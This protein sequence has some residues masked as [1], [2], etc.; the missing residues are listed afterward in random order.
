MRVDVP[1][2]QG[3]LLLAL[4]DTL[5]PCGHKVVLDWVPR[6]TVALA[7]LLSFIDEALF[8]PVGHR[9]LEAITF[10]TS[11]VYEEDLAREGAC[12]DVRRVRLLHPWMPLKRLD[13]RFLHSHNTK[14]ED[15]IS[16]TYL[17]KVALVELIRTIG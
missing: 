10:V 1:N 7:L 5:V 14:L 8:D 11:S 13:I 3:A 4:L 2:E 16:R 9:V 12:H 17:Y 15:K 6:N